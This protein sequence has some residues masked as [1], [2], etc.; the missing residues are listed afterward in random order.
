MAALQGERAERAAERQA[1]LVE[2][3]KKKKAAKKQ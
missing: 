3:R 2:L 1:E